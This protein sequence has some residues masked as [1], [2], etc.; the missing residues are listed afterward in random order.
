MWGKFP[1]MMAI[2]IFVVTMDCPVSFSR[3]STVISEPIMIT[4][5]NFINFLHK[6][7]LLGRGIK[8]SWGKFSCH[9]KLKP[10]ITSSLWAVHILMSY[11]QQIF[12]LKQRKFCQ[13]IIFQKWKVL[14]EICN[15]NLPEKLQNGFASLVQDLK[16]IC[17]KMNNFLWFNNLIFSLL[18]LKVSLQAS[19]DSELVWNI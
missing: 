18:G 7:T 8:L 12:L 19:W 16:D 15:L 13:R 6:K 5:C 9:D 14:C 17:I 2:A 11:N 10:C 1:F 3:W 4:W